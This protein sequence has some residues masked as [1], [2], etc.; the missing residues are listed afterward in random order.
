LQSLYDDAK[1]KQQRMLDNEAMLEKEAYE[2]A[3]VR[4]M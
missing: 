2:Q 1:Y 3:R 4:D